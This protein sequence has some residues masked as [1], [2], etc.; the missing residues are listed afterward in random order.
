MEASILL[1][2]AQ[3]DLGAPWSGRLVT[4]DASKVAQGLAY[5]YVDPPKVHE[6][7][8]WCSFRGDYTTLGDDGEIHPGPQKCCLHV[9]DLPLEEFYWHE[10]SRP[11]VDRHIG[12]EELAAEIW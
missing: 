6:W 5:I 4:S 2:L 7:S 11:G 1:P 10:I 9:A 12:L 8:R 3:L